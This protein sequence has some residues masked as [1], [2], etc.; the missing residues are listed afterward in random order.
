MQPFEIGLTLT[1]TISAGSY[2][3]GVIDFL[4][5]ALDEWEKEK[6]KNKGL[7]GNNFSKW[8]TPFHDVIIEGLS[9]ASGGGVTCG[10][11]M[12]TIGKNFTHV[13]TP[14][15]ANAIADNDFYDTWVNMLGIAQLLGIADLGPGSTL[16][17][18]LCY[19]AIDTIANNVINPAR[20]GNSVSRNYVSH[21]LYAF[22]TITNL[23]GIPYY[24][25]FKGN[26]ANQLMY[27]RH[28][29]YVKFELSANNMQLHKEDAY[30]LPYNTSLPAFAAGY[31][32]LKAA[33]LATCAI[34]GGFEA[35]PITQDVA[36]YQARKPKTPA[37]P[38]NYSNEFLAVDGGELNTQPFQVL[39]D[40]M[41]PV[42]DA[43]NP[44]NASEVKRTLIM[45]A[46]LETGDVFPIDYDISKDSLFDIIEPTLNS[47]RQ[48]AM[49]S[50][51]EITLAF[52]E[53]V[54]SRFIVAPVRNTNATSADR[55]S[56]GITGSILGAF[57]AFLSRDFR[58]HDFFLGRRNAQQFL[59]KS[60]ALPSEDA[61]QNPLFKLLANCDNY[62]NFTFKDADGVDYLPIIPLCG[63]AKNDTYFPQWPTGKGYDLIDIEN[64]L[65]VRIDEILKALVESGHFNSIERL[66]LNTAAALLK[67]KIAEAVMK[68][69]T[70]GL[71][72]SKL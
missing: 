25:N 72:D 16:K 44:R 30:F 57:G 19:K 59:R 13:R 6:E 52:D 71:A 31:T 69:V 37:F 41:L 29:D 15:A 12:N 58:E 61:L 51:Q 48:E 17:S 8:E 49:F 4:L 53:D 18:L 28:T 20:F 65:A 35:R 32:Q 60:F 36:Y 42:G 56:P 39:H 21:N 14:I 54:Y 1:G 34:P 5:E 10:L 2:T 46:P 40:A 7:Y 66:A 33:C 22:I 45:I 70:K 63:S 9:G 38:E 23:R 43:Q 62:N 24:L 67:D 50:A 47:M 11:F 27:Q 68:K 26:T 55:V 64:K 3:A